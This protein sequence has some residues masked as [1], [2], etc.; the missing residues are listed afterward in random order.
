M[1]LSVFISVMDLDIICC[2]KHFMQ[3]CHVQY[4]L[5]LKMCALSERKEKTT[6][7]FLVV[8]VLGLGFNSRLSF[9]SL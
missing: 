7:L 5:T 8:L 6:N 2:Y 3:T 9:K 1:F 4:Y